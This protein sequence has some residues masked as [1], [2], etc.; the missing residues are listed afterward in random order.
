MNREQLIRK[1]DETILAISQDKNICEELADLIEQEY[2]TKEQLEKAINFGI[3]LESGDLERNFK[4]YPKVV[5][6]FIETVLKQTK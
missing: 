1:I 4:K 2:Y 3:D 5:D 6:Q